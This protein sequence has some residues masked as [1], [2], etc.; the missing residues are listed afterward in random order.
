[1]NFCLR[2]LGRYEEAIRGFLEVSEARSRTLG[3]KDADTLNTRYWACRTLYKTGAYEMAV[4]G[5][6][7]IYKVHILQRKLGLWRMKFKDILGLTSLYVS[8]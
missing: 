1:M 8:Y 2:E 5:L 4:E 3:A 6:K 7:E